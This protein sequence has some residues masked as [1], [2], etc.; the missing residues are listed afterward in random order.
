MIQKPN[1]L[2][3]VDVETDQNHEQEIRRRA[4]ALYEER[5]REDGHDM[6]DWLDAEAQFTT[7]ALKTAA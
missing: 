6:D 2:K 5:G 7:A 4:Y 1:K 3:P